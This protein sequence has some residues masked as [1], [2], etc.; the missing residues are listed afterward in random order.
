MRDLHADAW[1]QQMNCS[2]E[3][4]RNFCFQLHVSCIFS[5]LRLFW[6][7]IFFLKIPS[8]ARPLFASFYKLTGVIIFLIKIFAPIYMFS[9]VY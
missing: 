7:S 5:I 4:V 1:I 3:S 6:T 9:G 8:I 2:I